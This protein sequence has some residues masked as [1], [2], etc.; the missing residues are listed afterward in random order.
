M[1]QIEKA[2]ME[3]ILVLKDRIYDLMD[4]RDNTMSVTKKAQLEKEIDCECKQLS[5]LDGIAR[6]TREEQTANTR[7]RYGPLEAEI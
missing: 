4:D 7:K 5:K 1:P 3:K 6:Y 2:S